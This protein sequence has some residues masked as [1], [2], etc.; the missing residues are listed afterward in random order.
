VLF[1][2]RMTEQEKNNVRIV[3]EYMEIT[4]VFPYFSSLSFKPSR[5]IVQMTTVTCFKLAGNYLKF[6]S[7]FCSYL[8]MIQNGLQL[9]MLP[10]F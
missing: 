4:S 5:K 6:I 1:S 2:V 7:N 9:K 10:I 3:K 8:A